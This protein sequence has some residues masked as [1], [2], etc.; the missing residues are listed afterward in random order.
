MKQTNNL[1]QLKSSLLAEFEKDHK[2]YFAI[3]SFD[4]KK[5]GHTKESHWWN[6]GGDNA[7]SGYDRCRVSECECIDYDEKEDFEVVINGY[8]E[9]YGYIKSFLSHALDAVAEKTAEAVTMENGW[10]T[11]THEQSLKRD[12]WLKGK[13]D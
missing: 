10:F 13:N 4:C 3:E 2:G 12:K 9:K 7:C 6:G 11:G 5:C 8:E 1:F